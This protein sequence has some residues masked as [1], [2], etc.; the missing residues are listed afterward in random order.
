MVQDAPRP[1]EPIP[2]RLGLVF[3]RDDQRSDRLARLQRGFLV[4]ARQEMNPPMACREF[5]PPMH[6]Q[7]VRGGRQMS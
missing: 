7:G 3:S 1:T 5:A 2:S 6:E 4:P